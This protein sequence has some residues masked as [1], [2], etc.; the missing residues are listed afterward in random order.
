[1]KF[2]QAFGEVSEAEWTRFC[3][4]SP[5]T[6]SFGVTDQTII[7]TSMEPLAWRTVQEV[8]HAPHGRV[9]TTLHPRPQDR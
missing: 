4:G 9:V 8:Y 2:I 1:M 7:M 6:K 3:A 5:I